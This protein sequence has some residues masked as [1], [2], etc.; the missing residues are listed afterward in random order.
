MARQPHLKNRAFVFKAS[1]HGRIIVSTASPKAQAQG[2]YTG[3]TLADAKAIF[4]DLQAFDD[5]PNLT[6]QLLQ[7]IAEWCIRFTPAAAPH[8]PDGVLLDA[9][10]CTHLW[11]GEEAYITDIVERLA[12][13]AY[14]ARAAIADTI[15]TAWAIARFASESYVIA[16]GHHREALSKLPPAALRLEAET[17][18]R[19]Y[20]LGLRS[21]EGFIAIP[22]KE[23]RSRFGP[24]IVQRIAQAL[25]EA[26]E[27][28]T[29]IFPF[30]PYEERLPCLEPIV[31]RTG[32]EIAL[33]CLLKTLCS[34]FRSE[35]KGLRSAYF[36]TYRMDS[37]AQGIEIE[38][39]RPS[40]HEEHLFHLFS[41]KLSTLEPKSGIELFALEA[42]KVE[43]AD[44]AQGNLWNV[45]GGSLDNEKFAQLIDRIAGKLGKETIQRYLPAEHYMPERSYQQ[46][47]SHEQ[48]SIEWRTD[49][50]RPLIVLPYPEPIEVTAPIPD[51][52]PMNFRY[53][54]RLHKVLRADGPERIEQEWWIE[55]GE[56][57]DYYAVEDEEGARYWLFRLGHY[58]AAGLPDK[59]Q[60]L[61]KII[62]SSYRGQSP[63]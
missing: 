10:G 46:A 52:P 2:I 16:S 34:R 18:E 24:Q 14:T 43:D 48:R 49:K 31:T 47:S 53:K 58:T 19:L 61:F 15:G 20:K 6:S 51:Y 32:I 56:H 11:G 12:A 9:T 54:G 28:F 29:P 55:E 36:R 35:G 57:R 5:K 42:T 45:N 44:P 41:L 33:E 1:S 26:E 7:R 13:R 3:M 59:H 63:C 22:R 30:Q 27:A 38:T 17:V 23:L 4:P 21:I 50:A 39:S 8:P 62:Q 25:G 40:H 37:T 60:S